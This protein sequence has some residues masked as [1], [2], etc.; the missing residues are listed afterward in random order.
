MKHLLIV[1]FIGVYSFCFGQ[2]LEIDH[3]IEGITIQ[4]STEG[5]Q[6]LRSRDTINLKVKKPTLNDSSV[7]RSIKVY[8]RSPELHD[9]SEI[10]VEYSY[11]Q[12]WYNSI[13]HES[14]SQVIVLDSISGLELFNCVRDRSYC[15]G[16]DWTEGNEYAW[17][18]Y[19]VQFN[20]D[21]SI[22]IFNLEEQNGLP[23]SRRGGDLDKLRADK[24]EGE[25]RY[26]AGKYVY[27]G[28]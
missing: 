17:Y 6:L 9:R 27:V 22:K 26:E 28:Q 16:T 5:F 12:G 13:D 23:V 24:K 21:G 20:A 1:S 25:Y 14:Q 19:K 2:V 10:I 4:E 11:S 15:Y 18:S 8:P 3:S 7:R